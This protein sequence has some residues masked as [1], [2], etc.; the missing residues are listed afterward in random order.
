MIPHRPQGAS[1]LPPAT[2]NLDPEDLKDALLQQAI[3]QRRALVTA[4]LRPGTGRLVK[5]AKV[6]I[7]IPVP[8]VPLPLVFDSPTADTLH[9]PGPATTSQLA[10]LAHKTPPADLNKNTANNGRPS[11]QQEDYYSPMEGLGELHQIFCPPPSHLP[12]SRLGSNQHPSVEGGGSGSPVEGWMRQ[13]AGGGPRPQSAGVDGNGGG[14]V[15]AAFAFPPP[16]S[17]PHGVEMAV[18][19]G[20]SIEG[21]AQKADYNGGGGGGEFNNDGGDDDDDFGGGFDDFGGWDGGGGGDDFDNDAAMMPPPPPPPSAMPPPP[22]R[23]RMPRRVILNPG[24]NLRKQ[25]PRKSLAIDPEVGRQ[26]DVDGMRRSTRKAQEPLKWWLGEQKLYDRIAHKTMPTI[27]NVTHTDPNT[28]WRTVADPKEW[29]GRSKGGSKK[30][31]AGGGSRKRKPAAAAAA[32]VHVG[33]EEIL[34]DEIAIRTGPAMPPADSDDEETELLPHSTPA[35]TVHGGDDDEDEAQGATPTSMRAIDL[36]S[37]LDAAAGGSG[38]DNENGEIEIMEI[39]DEEEQQEPQPQ[40]VL[41]FSPVAPAAAAAEIVDPE[42]TEDASWGLAGNDDGEEVDMAGVTP[43]RG[44]GKKGKKSKKSS[45][46][47]R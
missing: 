26:L 14:G 43:A 40:Q 29:R 31:R 34:D 11:A 21:S 45:K 13:A 4:S 27:I 39:D 16:P 2:D 22:P 1:P 44:G 42:A 17:A 12:S 41:S 9:M 6:S 24:V 7:N 10:Q 32:A 33:G 15:A 5:R 18:Q 35:T 8:V 30:S 38:G 37:P 46:G 23:P 3:A 28:P 47:R 20:T 25:L 19:T 36:T